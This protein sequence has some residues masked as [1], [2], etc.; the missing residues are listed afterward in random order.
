MFDNLVRRELYVLVVGFVIVGAVSFSAG[1]FLGDDLVDSFVT[2]N[3]S[4]QQNGSMDNLNGGGEE[5]Y[6]VDSFHF[7]LSQVLTNPNTGEKV[8]T[9]QE[10]WVR[11]MNNLEIDFRVESDNRVQIYNYEDKAAYIKQPSPLMG[12][13]QWYKRENVKIEDLENFQQSLDLFVSLALEFGEGKHDISMRVGAENA[14]IEFYSIDK[15]IDDKNF[16]PPDDANPQLIG[17]Q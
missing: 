12:G 1:T 4:T 11:G 16:T 17:Q 7:T 9:S 10:Y 13:A 8:E 5:G 14:E 3:D 6:E 2:D 15:E